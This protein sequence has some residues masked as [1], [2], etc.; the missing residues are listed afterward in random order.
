[1]SQEKETT[2]KFLGAYFDRDSVLRLSRW[3]GI[4][5]WVILAVYLVSWLISLAQF[6]IQFAS[7]LFFPKGMGLV[8]LLSMFTPFILQPLPGFIYFIALQGVSQMLLIFLDMEDS[9]RRAAQK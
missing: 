7:G 9:L 8:D 5:A 4:I 3:A 6:A 2:V 1:M